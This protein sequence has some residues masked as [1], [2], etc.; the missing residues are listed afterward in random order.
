MAATQQSV[1]WLRAKRT[2]DTN[3]TQIPK[4]SR[5]WYAGF[6]RWGTESQLRDS[7]LSFYDDKSRGR[8]LGMSPQKLVTATLESLHNQK[9]SYLAYLTNTHQAIFGKCPSPDKFLE[10]RVISN[11]GLYVNSTYFSLGDI[12]N[13]FLFL[14]QPTRICPPFTIHMIESKPNPK[15]EQLLAPASRIGNAMRS[16]TMCALR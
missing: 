14:S 11:R 13:V 10:I 3:A 1:Q 6:D 16:I 2:L 15:N 5:C 8:D 7:N 12:S 4:P 9:S